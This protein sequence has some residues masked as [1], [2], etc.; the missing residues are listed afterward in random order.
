MDY[1]SSTKAAAATGES[2]T[3]QLIT[4]SRMTDKSTM[5]LLLA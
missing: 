1:F 3:A 5:A 4:M 2:F